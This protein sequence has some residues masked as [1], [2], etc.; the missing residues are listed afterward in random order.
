MLLI[1][2]LN[3][4]CGKSKLYYRPHPKDG[5]G[6]VFSLSTL[7]GGESGQSPTWGGQVKVQPGEGVRSKSNGGVSGQSSQW[8]GG[9]SGQSSQGG[10]SSRGGGQHLAPS[11]GRYASCVHAGGLSCHIC[12]LSNVSLIMLYSL[13]PVFYCVSI[14]CIQLSFHLHSFC[15]VDSFWNKELYFLHKLFYCCWYNWIHHRYCGCEIC[16]RQKQ[17]LYFP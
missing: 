11:C 1:L 2:V 12:F 10:Q 16:Q 6:N 9:G 3:S 7:G 13:F 5:E 17:K 4:T 8:G 15:N 14:H